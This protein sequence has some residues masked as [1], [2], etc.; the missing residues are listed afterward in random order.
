MTNVIRA[1]LVLLCSSA[2]ADTDAHFGR[3][4]AGRL[5]GMSLQEV[6]GKYPG[7]FAWPNQPNEPNGEVIYAVT[8]TFTV[9]GVEVPSPLVHFVFSKDNGLQRVFFHFKPADREA[10]LY[11]V[12]Q[13]LGQDY[14]I[15]DQTL[16]RQFEWKPGQLAFARYEIGNGPNEPWAFFGVRTMT[17]YKT[18]RK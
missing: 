8:G 18:R 13:L 17:D 1:V 3:G 11:Q 6:Q 9:P 5:W 10:V 2:F 12:A 16:S 15:R 4:V 7:G 14:S